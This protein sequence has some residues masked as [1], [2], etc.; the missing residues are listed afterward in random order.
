[1]VFRYTRLKIL[2]ISHNSLFLYQPLVDSPGSS[3]EIGWN[4]V[5]S[6][7]RILF[8]LNDQ[9]TEQF[10]LL[11]QYTKFQL[12]HKQQK[13]KTKSS[14]NLH[15]HLST[16]TPTHICRQAT[17]ILHA[18]LSWKHKGQDLTGERLSPINGEKTDF[19]VMNWHRNKPFAVM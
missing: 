12:V 16:H 9:Y 6:D 1:M 15:S 5:I 7:K 10:Q 19:A 4:T 18:N 17:D 3:G 14:S 13:K 2:F 11:D 8:F